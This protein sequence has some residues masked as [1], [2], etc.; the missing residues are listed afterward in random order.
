MEYS[1]F[2]T[3]VFKKQFDKLCKKYPSMAEDVDALKE[4]LLSRPVQG[5]SLGHGLYK[6]RL[7][8]RSKGQG[9]SGGGRVITWIKLVDHKIVLVTMY[10]KSDQETITIKDLLKL[11]NF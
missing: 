8:I 10:D 11:I 9:K 3:S 4:S 6:V 1:I 2:A 7:V 5:E